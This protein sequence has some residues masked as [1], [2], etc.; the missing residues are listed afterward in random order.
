MDVSTARSLVKRHF[1]AI[2]R[3]GERPV[4]SR[5]AARAEAYVESI[6]RG[7][8]FE[9][10]RA[11]YPCPDWL[12]GSCSLTSGGA[13][14]QATANPFSPSV[15]ASGEALYAAS[16]E[17]LAALAEARGGRALE[18]RILVL[19]PAL[20]ASPI[21]PKAFDFYNP[22][23]HR[24][25]VA[26]LEAGRPAAVVAVSP[27]AEGIWPIFADPDLALSSV[28]IPFGAAGLAAEG[29]RLELE[30]EASTRPSR[31][32]T[33]SGLLRRGPEGAKRRLLCA[34]LDTKHYTPGAIDNGGCVAVLLAAA[35]L[36][37]SREG[38]AR[39]ALDGN[40][41]LEVVFFMGEECKAYGEKA[42]LAARG[43]TVADISFAMNCD[44]AGG[45][46]GAEGAGGISR[47]DGAGGTLGAEGA[48]DAGATALSFFN[49][50]EEAKAA[51][52]SAAGSIGSFREAGPW[53]ES[54]H[55]LFWPAGIPTIAATSA[56]PHRFDRIIHTPADRPELVDL[57][58]LAQLAE[59]AAYLASERIRR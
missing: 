22:E 44:G 29:A 36:V 8:G 2:M 48:G 53:Y 31:S 14:L 15:R 47:A 56:D 46:S 13:P 39:A 17:E 19:G 43:G 42:W 59:L 49:F 41:D 10:S 21:M 35:E 18:G 52:M 50:P 54:D 23:E 58:L 16:L 45:T 30:I 27:H 7:A 26:L 34:H 6:L 5:G 28:T 38:P 24:A 51:V 33:I 25:L 12:F 32:A 11:E 55:Y 37:A 4:G 9:V 57:D 3:I 40:S 20:C 1:E